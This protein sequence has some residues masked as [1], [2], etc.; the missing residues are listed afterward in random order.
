ML[1][2][3]MHACSQLLS[4]LVDG[5]VN[6]FLLQAVPDVNEVQL[7]LID[8]CSWDNHTLSAAQHARLYNP[9]DSGL[10]CLAARDQDQ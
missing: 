7:Q 4:A 8:T 9:L 3:C 10:G 6:N 2:I 1:S 5:R